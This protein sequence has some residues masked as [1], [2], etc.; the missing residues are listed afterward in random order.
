VHSRHFDVVLQEYVPGPPTRHFFIDGFVDRAGTIRAR[1]ARHRLRM[2][3]LDFGNSTYMT[4]VRVEEVAPA[5]RTLETLL[6]RLRYR[7]IFSAEFKLDERDGLYKILEM[8]ARPWW[9]IE[10][11]EQCR[12][13]VCSLAY[14]DALGEDVPTIERYA[15]GRTCVYPYFDFAACKGLYRSGKLGAF[16][17]MWSW[18]RSKQPV[19][20]WSDPYPS[21]S[22][23]ATLLKKSLSR[24]FGRSRE[25]PA[26][27]IAET[28]RL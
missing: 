16:A 28:A 21:L 6:T 9:Y 24:R 8:N 20:E 13:D 10:F 12:V 22:S 1:F 11:A 27:P 4:S 23:S 19:F 14:L 2:Y 18:L 5:M 7:G 3:P 15:V 26:R 17:W 25:L